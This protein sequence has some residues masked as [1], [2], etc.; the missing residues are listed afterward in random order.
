MRLANEFR[1]D[2]PVERTWP[3]LLDV[4]RVGSALP[5]AR[6]EPDPAGD[7]YRGTMEVK[8]GR[9]RE[10][11]ADQILERLE[12]F[13]PWKRLAEMPAARRRSRRRSP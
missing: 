3:L 13:G 5:G 10:E 11:D 12:R 6:L 8:L 2:A 1:L 4:P 9:I 7:S